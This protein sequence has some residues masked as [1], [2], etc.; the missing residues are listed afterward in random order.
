MKIL[1]WSLSE[2]SHHV[3]QEM[4][5]IRD[6]SDEWDDDDTASGERKKEGHRERR[7]KQMAEVKN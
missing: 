5:M 3:T 6:V 4:K 2:K 7:E 1:V